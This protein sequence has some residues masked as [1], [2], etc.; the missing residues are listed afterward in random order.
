MNMFDVVAK[1]Q[2]SRNRFDLSHSKKYS[3]KMG[4]LIPAQVTEVLPGDSFRLKPQIMTRFAP[5]ISPVMHRVRVYRHY[6]FVPNRLLWTSWGDYMAGKDDIG[7]HP[8]ITGSSVVSGSLADY[9][10]LATGAYQTGKINALPFAAYALIWD[11]WYRSQQLQEKRFVPL[12]AGSNNSAYASM[13]LTGPYLR[14]WQRDVFTSG[15]PEAQQGDPIQLPLT[16]TDE[17]P[18]TYRNRASGAANQNTG[19]LR[20]VDGDVFEDD[21][22]LTNEA[23]GPTPL[24]AGLNS[25][26]NFLAYDPAGTL[27]VTPNLE[28]VTIATLRWAVRMQEFFE[29]AARTGQR[30][31]EVIEANFP[32]RVPDSRLQRPEYIGG[33]TGNAVVSEVLSTAQTLNGAEIANPVG[34][35]AG[36]AIAV[37]GGNSFTYNATEHGWLFAIDSVLPETAYMQGNH[38]SLCNRNDRFDYAWPTFA[39]LGEQA[40]YNKEIYAQSADPDGVFAYNVRFHEYK[41]IPSTVAGEFRDTLD[42]WTLTRKFASEPTLSEDFIQCDIEAEDLTRIFAVTAGADHL[43]VHSINE[44]N[45]LRALPRYNIPTL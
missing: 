6:F 31:K 45:V 5:L 36:H 10:G 20:T 25:S 3:A 7:E 17:L 28:A 42:F 22:T 1:R 34:A 8:Y 12:V 15:L 13:L 24:I 2:P 23:P 41:Q 29:L 21:G 30:Y 26:G 18:V 44:C 35:Q 32:T 9:I 4:Q 19:Q 16:S 37:N 33:T 38:P 11:E 43:Y 40:I 27:V 14:G 39:Q